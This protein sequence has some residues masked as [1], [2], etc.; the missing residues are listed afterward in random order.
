MG[1]VVTVR[2]VARKREGVG[3]VTVRQVSRKMQGVGVV[4]VRIP[5]CGR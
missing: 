4:T 5:Q 1:I 3:V 2:Q